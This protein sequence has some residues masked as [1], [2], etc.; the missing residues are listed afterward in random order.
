[1]LA[2][3][4]G[5]GFYLTV[6]H[7]NDF[8]QEQRGQIF[9]VKVELREVKK[10]VSVTEPAKVDPVAFLSIGDGLPVVKSP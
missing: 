6:V 5:K 10:R 2:E 3:A 4:Y 9:L 8:L 7:V 1:M